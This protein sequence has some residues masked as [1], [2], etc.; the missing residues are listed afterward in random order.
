MSSRLIFPQPYVPFT[1]CSLSLIFPHHSEGEIVL[2]TDILSALCSFRLIFPPP[3]VPSDQHSLSPMF[4]Q[5]HIPS[6]LYSLRPMFLQTNIPSAIYSLSLMFLS[7][8]SPHRTQYLNIPGRVSAAGGLCVCCGC[9][10]AWNAC[11]KWNQSN[12]SS[13]SHNKQ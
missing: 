9:L 8:I 3:Y 13:M 11:R 6:V 7:L 4:P 2:Q 5:P 10:A 1:Q 12:W